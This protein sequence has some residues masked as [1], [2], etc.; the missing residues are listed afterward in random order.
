MT[1]SWKILSLLGLL[2]LGLPVVVAVAGS[3]WRAL[4]KV[5]EANRLWAHLAAGTSLF[6]RCLWQSFSK[7]SVT[8]ETRD[9]MTY[10]HALRSVLNEVSVHSDIEAKGCKDHHLWL[11]TFPSALVRGE[12]EKRW[13][14]QP[15]F[16]GCELRHRSIGKNISL[17]LSQCG[18]LLIGD[19]RLLMYWDASICALESSSTLNFLC[20]CNIC[21]PVWM[22]ISQN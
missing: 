17:S 13:E 11:W 1:F 20:H 14:S 15:G 21:L 4:A 19:E 3:R 6:R 16:P 9:S 5:C 8:D 10:V 12:E 22:L 2:L 7:Q 18:D